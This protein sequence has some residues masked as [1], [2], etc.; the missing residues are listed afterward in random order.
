MSL[1]T[2]Y[3]G[4]I[5]AF[6]HSYNHPGVQNALK[7]ENYKENHNKILRLEVMPSTKST[8]NP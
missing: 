2:L 5:N 1:S 6:L 3:A 8:K 7:E 4:I